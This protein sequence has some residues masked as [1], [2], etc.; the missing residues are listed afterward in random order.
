MLQAGTEQRN[1]LRYTM[2][3]HNDENLYIIQ[4]VRVRVRFGVKVKGRV[5]V[6]TCKYKLAPHHITRRSQMDSNGP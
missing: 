6:A 1:A 2:M 5:R 4:N 3:T